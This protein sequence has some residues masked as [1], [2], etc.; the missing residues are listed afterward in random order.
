MEPVKFRASSIGFRAER[1]QSIPGTLITH[2]SVGSTDEL[3]DP[4]C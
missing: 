3:R 1:A 4:G 2:S